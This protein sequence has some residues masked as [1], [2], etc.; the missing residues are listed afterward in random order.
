MLD[1]DLIN[2]KA[3]EMKIDKNIIKVNQ[4]SFALAKK[5]RAYERDFIKMNEDE[6]YKNQSNILLE[7]LNNNLDKKVFKEDFIESL[8]FSSIKALYNELIKAIVGAETNP[9]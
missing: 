3:I 4:P 7:F 1:L 9:N 6:I 5:V 8:T 2:G